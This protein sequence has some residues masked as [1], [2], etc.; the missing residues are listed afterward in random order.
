MTTTDRDCLLAAVLAAPGDIAPRL[1]LADWYEENGENLR[2]AYTR[3][4]GPIVY[5]RE[6]YGRWRLSY[7]GDVDQVPWGIVN[8]AFAA[9][10]LGVRRELDSLTV[11]HGFV[12]EVSAT[13]AGFMRVAINRRLFRSHPVRTVTIS[14]RRPSNDDDDEPDPYHWHGTSLPTSDVPWGTSALPVS[15]SNLLGSDFWRYE[16]LQAAHADLSS[17]C[18]AYGR[19]RAG[20]EPVKELVHV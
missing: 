10:P 20:L 5:R 18:V 13:M 9:L 2:A 17:A 19:K 8:E 15:I 16:S 7:G 12:E 1:A 6:R 3:L 4:P 11:R 14:D